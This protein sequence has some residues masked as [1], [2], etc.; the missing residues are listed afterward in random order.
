MVYDTPFAIAAIVR[1]FITLTNQLKSTLAGDVWLD[2]NVPV[3]TDASILDNG[4]GLDQDVLRHLICDRCATHSLVTLCSIETVY[5]IQFSM[6]DITLQF[7]MSLK[8][9]NKVRWLSWYAG[10]GH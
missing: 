3:L 10:E 6:S 8:A 9:G 7:R 1:R 4:V 2:Y 5:D